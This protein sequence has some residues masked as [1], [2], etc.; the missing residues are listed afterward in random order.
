[1]ST[2]SLPPPSTGQQQPTEPPPSSFET[3]PLAVL[4]GDDLTRYILNN[5]PPSEKPCS[6]RKSKKSR[7]NKAE[8]QEADTADKGDRLPPKLGTGLICTHSNPFESASSDDPTSSIR[9]QAIIAGRLLYRAS[10]RTWF[11]ASNPRR[12]HLSNSPSNASYVLAATGTSKLK[13]KNTWGVGDRVIGIIEDQKASADYYRVNIFGSHSALLHVLSFEGATKRN[14]PQLDPGCLIYCR[15]VKSFAG[16]R[17]DPEV[18]CKVGGGAGSSGI[19]AFNE[20][21]VEEDDGGASRKDWLTNEGTYGPLQ[22]GTSFRVSLGLAR[23]LL[24][25]KNVVLSALDQSGIP[26]EIAIGV[27]G[28]VWVN[29]PESEYTI[30][31]LNAIQNSEVMSA[32]QVR[33]MVKMMAKNVKKKIE[34]YS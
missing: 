23:E 16:G 1:M 3:P 22:G 5:P 19:T 24:N 20:G 28:M 13:S 7:S 33:G 8:E 2:E 32:E 30:T 4:P 10:S 29:S 27:N 9:I 15:V 6:A 17:M 11:I 34:E 25:P 18:S 26:F 31:V 14:R 21:D 12:Y